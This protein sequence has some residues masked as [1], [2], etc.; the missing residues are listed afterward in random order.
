[1][2]VSYPKAFIKYSTLKIWLVLD[3]GREGK[4]RVHLFYE[5]AMIK[6]HRAIPCNI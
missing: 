4:R 1:M 2:L 6:V 5:H 3:S